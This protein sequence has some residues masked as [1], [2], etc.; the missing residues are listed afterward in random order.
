MPRPSCTPVC[1]DDSDSCTHRHIARTERYIP[2]GAS[3]CRRPKEAGVDSAGVALATRS[4]EGAGGNGVALIASAVDCSGAGVECSISGNAAATE[5]RLF[6]R[7]RLDGR[8]AV[9]RSAATR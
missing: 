9:V 8:G 2:Y 4:G 1:P 3:R 5:A 6:W 7:R